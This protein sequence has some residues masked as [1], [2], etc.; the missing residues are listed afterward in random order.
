VQNRPSSQPVL[1]GVEPLGG[2]QQTAARVLPA[3]QRLDAGGLARVDVDPGLVVQDDLAAAHR[4]Q[5]RKLLH[6]L[7]G[8]ARALAR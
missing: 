4:T 8:S 5:T 6:S 2:R 3:R 7:P 1:G